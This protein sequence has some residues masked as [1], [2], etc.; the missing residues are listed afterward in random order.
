MPVLL[1]VLVRQG[2]SQQQ[3]SLQLPYSSRAVQ[4]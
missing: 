1:L 2:Q 3:Q 4:H